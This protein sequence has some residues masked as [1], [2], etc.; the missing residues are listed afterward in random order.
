MV[1]DGHCDLLFQLWKYNYDVNGSAK[2]QFDLT[3]WRNSP[4]R[5]QAFAIFVPEDVPEQLQFNVALQMVDLFYRRIIEPNHDIIHIK[6]RYD[7][8]KLADHQRGAI[9]TLEGCHPIG[10]DL[11]KLIKLVDLGVRIVGLTW[12]NNNAVADSIDARN[13]KGLSVFGKEVV[14]YLNQVGVWTDVSHLSIR[15]FYDVIELAKYVMASHSNAFSVCQHR[16]NLD[17]QQIEA[18][19]E[20]DGWIGITFVPFFTKMTE[21]VEIPDLIKHIDY[22]LERGAVNQLGFGSDF[23]GITTTIRGLSSVQDYH[24]L[25]NYLVERY[26]QTILAKIKYENFH[27]KFPAISV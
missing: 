14:H 4:V 18:L 5:V 12:N 16:R 21:P 1:I 6:S 27:R 9:L 15:G 10:Q 23:D 2:L 8:D 19:I 17:D 3:K 26:D 25:L 7:L 20:S 22:F 24:N 13:G 11:N